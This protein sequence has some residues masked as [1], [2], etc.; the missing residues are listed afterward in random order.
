MGWQGVLKEFKGRR[1]WEKLP[2]IER[3]GYEF[4]YAA[5]WR[6]HDVV[7]LFARQ[8]DRHKKRTLTIR[9]NRHTGERLHGI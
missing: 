4:D 8:L 5:I 1:Y 7:Y 6:D 9:M 3:Q 2:A